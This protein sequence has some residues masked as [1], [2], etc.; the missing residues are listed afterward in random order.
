METVERLFDGSL[1]VVGDVHG[2]YDALQDLLG[3]LN[4]GPDG[5]HPDGRRLVFVGDLIDRGPDSPAVAE[6]VLNMVHAGNAQGDCLRGH[7]LRVQISVQEFVD[8][9]Q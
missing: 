3:K 8:G 6:Q 1:D 9:R 5:S 4:Y 2:Q 7:A